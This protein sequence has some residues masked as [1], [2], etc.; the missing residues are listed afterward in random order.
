MKKILIV[1]DDEGPLSALQEALE[2]YYT[3]TG[4]QTLNSAM[5]VLESKDEAVDMV[6][7]DYHLGKSGTA[8]DLIHYIRTHTFIKVRNLP[9]L[10]ISAD[11]SQKY[12]IETQNCEF[13]TKPFKLAQLLESIKN[14]I[15]E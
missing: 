15:G 5:S 7:T 4:A 8:N 2:A 3:I 1:D 9:I 6:I 10:V 14:K 13:M 11:K 12:F